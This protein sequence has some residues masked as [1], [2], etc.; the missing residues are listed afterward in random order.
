MRKTNRQEKLQEKKSRYRYVQKQAVRIMRPKVE[1][2]VETALDFLAVRCYDYVTVGC[3]AKFSCATLYGILR[4]FS[5]RQCLFIR[6]HPL[7]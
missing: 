4:H 6:L 3:I 2:E 7:F 5:T 1:G